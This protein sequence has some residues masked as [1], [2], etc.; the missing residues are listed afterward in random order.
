V[1]E[2]EMADD[3]A[4]NLTSPPEHALNKANQKERTTNVVL[5]LVYKY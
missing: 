1:G 3:F 2:E 4:L 5:D